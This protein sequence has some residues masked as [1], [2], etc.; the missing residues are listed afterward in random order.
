MEAISLKDQLPPVEQQLLLFTNNDLSNFDTGSLVEHGHGYRWQTVN[1]A[2]D[3]NYYTHW[4][5]N[6]PQNNL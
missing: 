2:Q 3:I 5:P 6:S 4:M 1:G